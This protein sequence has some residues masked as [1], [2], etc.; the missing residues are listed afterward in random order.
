M[1]TTEPRPKGGATPAAVTVSQLP[2]E[3]VAA[4]ATM[5][6]ASHRASAYGIF[7][8]GYGTFWMLGS[9][10]LGGLYDVSLVWT[11]V[12]AI[13]LELAAIPFIVVTAREKEIRAAR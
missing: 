10:M 13:V 12:A 8:A 7:T 6:P 4:V 9:A 5:V 11:A 3:L 2:P 1:T